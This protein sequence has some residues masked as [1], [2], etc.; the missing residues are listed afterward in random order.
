M[1]ENQGKFDI[2]WYP[3]QLHAIIISEVFAEY[4][5]KTVLVTIVTVLPRFKDFHQSDLGSSPLEDLNQG[6]YR[7]GKHV[8]HWPQYFSSCKVILELSIKMIHD[9][10]DLSGAFISRI[11][12]LSGLTKIFS[13][14]LFSKVCISTW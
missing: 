4:I 7:P 11:Y 10:N 14:P 13:W 2:V 6:S 12:E 9:T 8:K 3:H 5:E 1:F